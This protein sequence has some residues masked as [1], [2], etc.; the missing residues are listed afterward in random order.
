MLHTCWDAALPTGPPTP[1]RPGSGASD[2]V[3]ARSPQPRADKVALCPLLPPFLMW[4]SSS[5]CDQNTASQLSAS[6]EGLGVVGGC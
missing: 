6:W 1:T 3:L 5:T 2:T 4:G